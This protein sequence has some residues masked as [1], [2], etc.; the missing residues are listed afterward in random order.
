MILAQQS[1]SGGLDSF[2][3]YFGHIIRGSHAHREL[4]SI[5]FCSFLS[6]GMTCYILTMPGLPFLMGLLRILVSRRQGNLLSSNQVYL[7]RST[8]LLDGVTYLEWG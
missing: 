3:F 6:L 1:A 4:V 5:A 8:S 7:P 2:L